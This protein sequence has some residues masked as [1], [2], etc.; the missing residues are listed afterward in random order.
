MYRTFNEFD[1]DTILRNSPCRLLHMSDAQ[2]R[3]RSD[4]RRN[5][6]MP[7]YVEALRGT[8]WKHAPTPWRWPSFWAMFV[9]FALQ[10]VAGIFPTFLC[11]VLLA[12]A[13]ATRCPVAIGAERMRPFFAW[14]LGVAIGVFCCQIMTGETRAI[15]FHWVIWGSTGGFYH[16]WRWGFWPWE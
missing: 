6:Q 15:Q 11:L 16:W 1:A 3:Q 9:G 10:M 14:L 5:R 2:Q 12:A 4:R 8:R 13:D 7:S